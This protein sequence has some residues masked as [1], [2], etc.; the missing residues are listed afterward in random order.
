MLFD[1]KVETRQVIHLLYLYFFCFYDRLP[2]QLNDYTELS[3]Y[4]FDLD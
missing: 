3:I 2:M 4:Q 1:T